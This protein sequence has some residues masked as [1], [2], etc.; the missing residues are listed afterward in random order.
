MNEA[1]TS[2]DRLHDIALP[3]PVPWWPPAP[4]WYALFVLLTVVAAWMAWRAWQGWR[5][6]AYRRAALRELDALGDAAAIAELLRRTAL[7][8]APRSVVAANTGIGWTNWLDANAREP[9]PVA[10]QQLL[11]A[12]VYGRP[13]SH[14]EL[15]ALRAYAA[16]W[17]THHSP[18][19]LRGAAPMERV[20]PP[21]GKNS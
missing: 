8:I 10:V 19:S 17:I 6:N 3:A 2:L 18:A 13:T 16:R 1:A 9:M 4:G 5:A 14:R 12:G 11:I 7:V 21:I 20:N 15:S